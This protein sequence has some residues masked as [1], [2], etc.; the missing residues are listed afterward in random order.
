MKENKVPSLEK[1]II[2]RLDS[3]YYKLRR[4]RD[5]ADYLIGLLQGSY[6]ATYGKRDA[7][8][9]TVEGLNQML[10]RI[11]LG[12]DEEVGRVWDCLTT[13]ERLIKEVPDKE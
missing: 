4:A 13:L 11:Q 6:C 10:N 1:M 7:E 9:R 5:F 8:E 12:I 3:N 2:T